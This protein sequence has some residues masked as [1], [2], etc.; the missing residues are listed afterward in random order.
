MH[1]IASDRDLGDLTAHPGFG[2][3]VDGHDP[4]RVARLLHLLTRTEPAATDDDAR[5]AAVPG[6][7]VVVDGVEDLRQSMGR[8][9]EEPG[10]TS[11]G[12]P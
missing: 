9:A 1:A 12:S 11:S 3:L 7:L 5:D 8:L 10:P 6:T 2:T 4:R